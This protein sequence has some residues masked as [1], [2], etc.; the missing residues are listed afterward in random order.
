[1]A[2]KGRVEK[3][4]FVH[5]EWKSKRCRLGL[6]DPSQGPFRRWIAWAL[7]QSTEESLVFMGSDVAR[8]RRRERRLGKPKFSGKIATGAGVRNL[9]LGDGG[10][11]QRKMCRSSQNHEGV[12]DLVIA[13]NPRRWVWPLEGIGQ[14]A[15]G[16]EKSA[17]GEKPNAEAAHRGVDMGNGQGARPA[18]GQV[19]NG[20]KPLWRA[21]PKKG[22]R[23][24]SSGH[25]TKSDEQ[26]PNIATSA[27][28]ETQRGPGAHDEHE[29]HGVIKASHPCVPVGPP[30]D[31]VVEGAR[32]KTPHDAK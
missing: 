15:D 16:V 1:V 6:E 12:K 25:H 10:S 13:K 2:S 21:G 20:P 23:D 14:G 4:L 22:D 18:D 24:P 26:G 19:E 17:E 32:S 3:N 9:H 31:A 29:D 28:H 7:G 8:R 30:L 5:G 27:S 11:D